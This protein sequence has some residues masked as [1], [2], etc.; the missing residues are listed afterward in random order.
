VDRPFFHPEAETEYLKAYKWYEERSLRA[1]QKFEL[2][3]EDVVSRIAT[4]P[5]SFPRYD[6]IHRFAIVRRFP[7]SVVYQALF[8]AIY[9]VAVAHS[10]RSPDYWRGRA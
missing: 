8:D 6:D 4:A 5:E 1:A 7:Y 9:V 10:S 3:V 2:E